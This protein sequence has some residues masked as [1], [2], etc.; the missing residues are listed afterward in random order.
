MPCRDPGADEEI[1]RENAEKI[2]TLTNMLCRLCKLAERKFNLPP[3]ILEWWQAH[4][5]A[6]LLRENEER[7]QR[8]LEKLKARAKAKLTPEE[9][10]ALGL[11]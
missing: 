3:D 8:E 4:Q 6:D 10:K 7:K 9:Q 11:R 5:A 2:H 1:A